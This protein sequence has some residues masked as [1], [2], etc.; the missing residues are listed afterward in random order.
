MDK[1]L[2]SDARA[3]R[4]LARARQRGF[5]GWLGLLSWRRAVCYSRH[6]LA[7]PSGPVVS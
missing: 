4:P 1:P 7:G 6:P 2:E 3:Y 5:C